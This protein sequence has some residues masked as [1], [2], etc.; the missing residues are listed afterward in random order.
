MSTEESKRIARDVFDALNRRDLDSVVAYYAPDCRFHGWPPQTMDVDGYKAT[1]SA[2]LAAFPDSRFSV[3]DVIAAGG[4]VAVRHSFQ[5]S[6]QAEF[7]G[8]PA[9]GRQVHVPAIVILDIRDGE[10]TEA[11]LNADFLGMLQ[12]LGAIPVPEQVS[13]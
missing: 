12:Q 6:Q 8:I 4:K 7:Q 13:R 1:M 3:D 5:G 10:V 2:L 11:W 9:T